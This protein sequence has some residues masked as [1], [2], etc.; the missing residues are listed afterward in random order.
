[1]VSIYIYNFLKRSVLGGQRYGLRF[2]T[3]TLS[4]TRRGLKIDLGS[5]EV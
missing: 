3:L 2:L 4:N 5:A 1:M